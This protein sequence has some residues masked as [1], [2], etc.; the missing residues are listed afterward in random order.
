MGFYVGVEKSHLLSI[1]WVRISWKTSEKSRET[2]FSRFTRKLYCFT[3]FFTRF[4]LN[5]DP[6]LDSKSDLLNQL[7]LAQ[8]GLFLFCHGRAWPIFILSWPSLAQFGFGDFPKPMHW[9]L[10]RICLS[11]FWMESVALVRR[12]IVQILLKFCKYFQAI[13]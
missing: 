11:L 4:L 13:L 12:I 10:L 1:F 5:S 7:G 9:S 6:K 2:W 8:L 3:W